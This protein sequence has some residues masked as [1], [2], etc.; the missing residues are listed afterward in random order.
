M[1]IFQFVYS[2]AP[3]GPLQLQ[4]EPLQ[5]C[6]LGSK[7]IK[8]L[9]KVPRAAWGTRI[10][11]GRDRTGTMTLQRL[12]S[13]TW[14][15]VRRL[16]SVAGQQRAFVPSSGAGF[17]AKWGAAAGVV[18]TT[19]GGLQW[20]YGSATNFF[21]NRFVTKSSKAANDIADFYG[22]EDF[23]QVLFRV[24]VERTF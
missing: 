22:C 12:L 15:H 4:N 9:Q 10:R 18:A 6:Q 13:R 1:K 24:R 2:S 20:A 21:D 5:L 8:I 7:R 19:L 23:M 3:K 16:S 17:R 14:P 11:R